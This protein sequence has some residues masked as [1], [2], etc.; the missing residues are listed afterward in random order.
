MEDVNFLLKKYYFHLWPE[1]FI[2]TS[3]RLKELFLFM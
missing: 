2:L 1:G 3:I